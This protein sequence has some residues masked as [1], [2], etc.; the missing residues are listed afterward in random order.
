[1]V[2][3]LAQLPAFRNVLIHEYVN[4]DFAKVV[5]ALDRLEPVEEF[6]RIIRQ[7]EMSQD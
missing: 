2:A 3:A 6:A 7:M 4:L 5:E 1:M